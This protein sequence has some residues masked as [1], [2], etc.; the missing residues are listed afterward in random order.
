MTD[1]NENDYPVAEVVETTEPVLDAEDVVSSVTPD[2]KVMPEDDKPS[3]TIPNIENYSMF[4]RT[5]Q[6]SAIRTLSEALKEV[7]TDVNIHFDKIRLQF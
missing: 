4:L 7:L 2:S 5:I 6:A 3:L 1:L